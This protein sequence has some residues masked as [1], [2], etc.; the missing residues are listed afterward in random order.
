MIL[1]KIPVKP[2]SAN[3]M[4][5]SRG[6]SKIKTNTYRD[7]QETFKEPLKDIP[8]TFGDDLVSIYVEAGLSSKQADLDN[9][10]KP[11]LDTLQLVYD[12]FNDNKVYHLS[13]T[14]VIVKKGSEYISVQIEPFKENI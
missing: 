8:W 14:K 2:F 4:F 9:V 1:F 7:Y 12:E 10:L 3:Q 6:R 11:L 5:W 13:T